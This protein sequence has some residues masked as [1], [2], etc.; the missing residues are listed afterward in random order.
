MKK[1][2]KIDHCSITYNI[3]TEDW[4]DCIFFP[5]GLAS[6]YFRKELIFRTMYNIF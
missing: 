2:T 5:A 6:S 4:Y 1:D 3:L